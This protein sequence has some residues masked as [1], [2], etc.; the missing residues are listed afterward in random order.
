MAMTGAVVL[1]SAVTVA[2]QDSATD[3]AGLS[4]EQLVNRRV[5]SAS[6][7]EQLVAETPAAVY[8]ITRDEIRRSGM[9]SLPEILRLA[10]GVQVAQ[11]NSNKWA[12]SIRG[13]NAVYANKLL[14][15]V[16]GRSIY[17]RLFAGVAWDT[18]DLVLD[19]IERIEVIRGPGAAMWGANAVNGV[20]NIV[21][22]SSADTE[23]LFTK[24]NA[25]MSDAAGVTMRYGG[26]IGSGTYRVS[27]RR[28]IAATCSRWRIRT[29]AQPT[30]GITS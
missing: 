16:D 2:A 1:L 26:P 9:T 25:G 7:K 8:V 10:P 5:T 28:G 22:R 23:G 17:Y 12:I 3:V 21:T 30:T 24:V 18:E 6:R 14:V 4:L 11:V 29:T 20:I 27:P 13:F 15:L 19:D